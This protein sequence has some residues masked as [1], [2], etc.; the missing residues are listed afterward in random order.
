[1]LYV[2]SEVVYNIP[3]TFNYIRLFYSLWEYVVTNMRIHC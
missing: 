3:S 2:E 1:M